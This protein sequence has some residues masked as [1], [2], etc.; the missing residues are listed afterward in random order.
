MRTIR[1][2]RLAALVTVAAMAVPLA[3]CAADGG[4]ADAAGGEIIWADWGGPTTEARQAAYFDSFMDDSGVDLITATMEEAVYYEMI[5]GGAGDYDVVAS[6]AADVYAYAA[7]G[8][9][10]I[11]ESARGDLL[12]EDLQP[13]LLGGFVFGTAQG[14]LTE[15]FPEGG[16]QD[17][18]DFFDTE[19]Y[20]GKRAWPGTPGMLDASYEIALLADGVAPEDLY[21]LDVARAEAKLDTIREDLV[22]YQ[23]YPEVQQLLTSESVSIA[24]TVTGQFTAL[25]NA[26]EDVTVQWNQAFEVPSGMAIPAAAPHPDAAKELAEWVADPEREARFVEATGYGPVH[27]ETFDFLTDD[28]ASSLVNAPANAELTLQWDNEW[29]GANYATLMDSYTAWLAG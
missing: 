19:T 27:A 28:V 20:P 23:S 24:V 5:E 6:A 25:R 21:P 17:W 13:Y 16:P 14:W 1:P 4:D 15:T 29:R 11:P 3:A 26:G 7:D 12:P 2:S 8:M 18:A 22:F 9:Q 10:E